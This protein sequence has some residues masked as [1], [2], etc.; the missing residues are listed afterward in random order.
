MPS[1]WYQQ[2]L[3]AIVSL[4]AN[5]IRLAYFKRGKDT[6]SLNDIDADN[7]S[8]FRWGVVYEDQSHGAMDRSRSLQHR[9]SH[10]RRSAIRHEIFRMSNQ[11]AS[12]YNRHG[13]EVTNITSQESPTEQANIYRLWECWCL[14]HCCSSAP[15]RAPQPDRA[16]RKRRRRC[17]TLTWSLWRR[18]RQPEK[19]WTLTSWSKFWS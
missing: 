13:L 12:I 6:Q 15:W 19:T 1:C 14:T 16:W 7:I 10:R 8:D 18:T 4:H 17:R 3:V 9:M 2:Q 5:N 11:R